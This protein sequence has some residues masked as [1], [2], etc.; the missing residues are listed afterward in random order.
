MNWTLDEGLSLVRALQKDSRKFNYHIALGGGV[1]NKGT[2]DKD[3]DLYFM[4]LDNGKPTNIDGLIEWLTGMWGSPQ[5]IGSGYG[6]S[7]ESANAPATWETIRRAS[8]PTGRTNPTTL[9]ELTEIYRNGPLPR[10]VRQR[11]SAIR[12]TVEYRRNTTGVPTTAG[13]SVPEDLPFTAPLYSYTVGFVAPTT[14]VDAPATTASETQPPSP[15]T[16]KLKFHRSED[17]IDVF[18]LG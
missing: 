14:E 4:A 16:R 8:S 13:P 12:P 2:S 10:H 9:E 6:P 17:R 15:Y 5:D 11:A 1:L 18:I 3:L 7:V